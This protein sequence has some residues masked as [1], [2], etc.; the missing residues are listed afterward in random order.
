MTL[1]NKLL[2]FG[3]K[4]V[5]E[6]ESNGNG[7]EWEE[8]CNLADKLVSRKLTGHAARDEILKK[9]KKSNLYEWNFFY[10][11]ILQKDMRC[12]LSEKTINNVAKK[13]SFDEYIIPVFA[14]QLA[15]DS[16]LHKKK[17]NGEKF[18]EVKLDGVRVITILY[19]N[20]KVDM[21]SR[22]GKN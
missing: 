13:N 18:L 19:P 7:L 4:Q 20:G 2:T 14:C 11:R 16:E 21:F 6:S 9:M 22:N 5:P 17:L 10:K 12:G 15:Q 1:Y 8:F 3:V